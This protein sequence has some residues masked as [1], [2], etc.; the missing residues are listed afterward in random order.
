MEQAVNEKHSLGQRRKL[1]LITK[2]FEKHKL[3]T[4]Q[5]DTSALYQVVSLISEIRQNCQELTGRVSLSTVF[6]EV[7][8]KG[9]F[10]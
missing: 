9:I 7:L 6:K 4:Y 2:N 3:N 5:E 10:F 1:T 8:Q